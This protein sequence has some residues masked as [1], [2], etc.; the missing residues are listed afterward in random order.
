MTLSNRQGY[1]FLLV[2]APLAEVQ[3]DIR[4]MAGQVSRLVNLP[5][6]AARF[7]GKFSAKVSESLM[8]KQRLRLALGGGSRYIGGEF[9]T[10]VP[11]I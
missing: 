6:R 1:C 2:A 3:T 10:L 7:R 8:R 4:T 11:P 5:P 9:P